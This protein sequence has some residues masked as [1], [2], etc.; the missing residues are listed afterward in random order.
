MDS[1]SLFGVSEQALKIY[2]KRADILANNLVNTSTPN[3]KAQDIDFK[4]AMETLQSE[5][6][7]I[8]ARPN[9][10]PI[11]NELFSGSLKYRVPTQPALDGNTVDADIE[12]VQ[13]MENSIKYQVSLSFIS[14]S[15]DKLIRAFRGE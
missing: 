15:A 10:I 8:A 3:Y 4:S 7:S 2:N 11:Q 1:N 12:R 13:F 5:Q 14:N 6:P 9:D